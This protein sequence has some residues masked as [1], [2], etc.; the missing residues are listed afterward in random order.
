MNRIE[1]KLWLGTTGVAELAAGQTPRSYHFAVIG[2]GQDMT[3]E[4]WVP[5]RALSI[6]PSEL[7]NRTA[8]VQEAVRQLDAKEVELKD[9]LQT[10]LAKI[11]TL[12]QNLLC[13]EA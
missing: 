11:A 12:R 6:E 13:L 2:D 10:E 7:P 9:K 4:G 3:S 1:L 8:C 5:V